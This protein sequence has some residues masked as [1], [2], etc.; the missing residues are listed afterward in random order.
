MRTPQEWM[1]SLR[2]ENSKRATVEVVAMA[3]RDAFLAGAEAMRKA[4]IK[5]METHISYLGNSYDRQA[6]GSAANRITSIDAEKL[7]GKP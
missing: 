3:Q 4:I 7:E 5:E 2:S 1:D 6:V